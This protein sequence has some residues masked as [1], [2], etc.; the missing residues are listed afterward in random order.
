MNLG[1]TTSLTEELYRLS[2]QQQH[3]VLTRLRKLNLNEYQA[4]TLNYIA[5]HNGT[6]QKELAAYLGK[7]TATVTNIL[8]GLETKGYITRK[9][10]AG[11][12]RQKQLYLTAAGKNIVKQIQQIFQELET[13]VQQQLSTE[14]CASLAAIL[15][16]LNQRLDQ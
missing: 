15:Q 9:I 5:G 3:F 14:Q 11:N 4:R 12:E 13:K 10:P 7:Q 8:K 1:V 6:I 2:I 16:Q